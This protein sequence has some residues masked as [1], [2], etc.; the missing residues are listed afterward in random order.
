MI[1]HILKIIW[2]QRRSNGWIFTELL[3][4][5]AVLWVMM[6]SLLVDIYTYN[7][8]LGFDIRNVYAVRV[9]K[10]TPETPGYVPDSL[11]AA[12][13]GEDLVRLADNLRRL[14][15]VE[16]ACIGAVACPYTWS[17]SWSGLVWADADSTVEVEYFQCF[18]VTPSYF[19]VFRMTDK[20]GN[21]L[22]AIIE[23]NGEQ[24]VISAD[25]EKRFFKGQSGMGQRV[26]WSTDDMETMGIAG[27]S[28]PIRQTEYVKSAPCF[29]TLM[30]Q[31]QD[32]VE[33][34]SFQQAQNMDCLIR[35]K[36]GFRAEDME[37]FLQGVSDRLTVNNLYVSSITPLEEMRTVILKERT[38]AMK[39][40]IA[41]VVF[42]LVNVFF[43]IVGTFW[44]RTQYRR[45]E[46][47]LRAA[48][49][50]SRTQLKRFMDVEGLSLLVFTLPL[51]VIF[52]F[53]ML[54]FDFPDT[55]RLPYTWWRFVL[56]FGGAALLLGG[57][58]LAGIWFP[59]RKIAKMNPS[60]AL[61]YE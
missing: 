29:Y 44:L 56:A 15:E 52:I 16:E 42:M 26:K 31:E 45:G 50:A 40:K 9:G 41:L 19:D 30:R 48:V 6:D 4:V 2:N 11:P 14:P 55:Y 18:A 37:R 46:L 60:D 34:A 49:G 35:M 38:D 36:E 27:V 20:N 53:N 1:K 24:I 7:L 22:R 39:K 28:S 10:M 58:I 8:P 25:L 54:Y 59:S 17:N 21:P 3:V 5:M 47:G 33:Q 12:S 23:K 61:H 13:D 43:G 57:M 51:V 32:I